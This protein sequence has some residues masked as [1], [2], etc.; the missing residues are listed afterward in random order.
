[1]NYLPGMTAR[2]RRAL[3][4]LRMRAEDGRL[5]DF[6]QVAADGCWFCPVLDHPP[7]YG[8]WYEPRRGHEVEQR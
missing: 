1:M 3:V 8:P 5:S 2:Q 4:R 7:N 6:D